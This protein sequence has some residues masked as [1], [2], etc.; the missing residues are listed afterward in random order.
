MI[1]LLAALLLPAALADTEEKKIRTVLDDQAAAW[2]KGDLN[3]FMSGYWNSPDLS[4]YSGKDKKKG[5]DETFNNYKK[6]YQADGKEMGT[7]TFSEE[8]VQ[9]LGP[10]HAVVKGRW[11]VV[12][13]KEI[14]EGLYTLIMR[15]TDQGWKIVHD[16]TSV[17]S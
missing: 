16:H 11:K 9:I 7:L 3:G 5:W 12:M 15:K 13:K 1:P 4:F 14:L 6:R 10:E 8:E 2:N 17:G